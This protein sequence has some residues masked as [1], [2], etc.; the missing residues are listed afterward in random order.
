MICP[1][2]NHQ[3][4][5]AREILVKMTFLKWRNYFTQI[6][7]QMTFWLGIQFPGSNLIENLKKTITIL[8]ALIGCKQQWMLKKSGQMRFRASKLRKRWIIFKTGGNLAST[9][10]MSKT[11]VKNFWNFGIFKIILRICSLV[12][13][14]NPKPRN[15]STQRSIKRLFGYH[16]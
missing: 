13:T 8:N 2:L 4:I 11:K 10:H 3:S 15:I 7:F 1:V 5:L 6:D 16:L 12:V 14:T 9:P